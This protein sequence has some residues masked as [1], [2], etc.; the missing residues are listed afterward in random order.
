VR[1][2][3]ELPNSV[4]DRRDLAFVGVGMHHDEHDEFT[5]SPKA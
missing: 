5:G 2:E 4:E 1:R 3:L